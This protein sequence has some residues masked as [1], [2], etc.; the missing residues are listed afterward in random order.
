[1]L[2]I[3]NVASTYMIP[4]MGDKKIER[5]HL[6]PEPDGGEFE[7]CLQYSSRDLDADIWK[8]YNLFIHI[9]NQSG[10]YAGF[11]ALHL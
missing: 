3:P 8:E 5:W 7:R 11:Y 6:M 9:K 2:L 10:M 4:D 1:M